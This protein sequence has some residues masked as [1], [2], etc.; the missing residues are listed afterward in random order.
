MV[1]VGDTV[2]DVL[3]AGVHG[4]PAIGVAWGYGSVEQMREAG[5]VAIAADTQALLS[6][7]T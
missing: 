7:L 3:G 2:F 1:M 4:I 6:L 5:A